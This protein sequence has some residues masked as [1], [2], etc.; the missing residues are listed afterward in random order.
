ML[1]LLAEVPQLVLVAGAHDPAGVIDSVMRYKPDVLLLDHEMTSDVHAL[2]RR[3]EIDFSA[4]GPRVLL[5]SAR[6]HPA[7]E[8]SCAD[9]RVCGFVREQSPLAQIHSALRMVGACSAPRLWQGPCG[10]FPLIDSIALSRL[11]L[12]DREY[13]V[14]DRIGRGQG[15]QHIAI[16]LGL[17]VKTV[18]THRESIKHK[19]RLESASALADP[20]E[21]GGV[22]ITPGP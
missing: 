3:N 15:T 7:T 13:H 4:S 6:H 16:E 2:A 9:D 20:P 22:A 19:L 21:A 5:I 8:S 18:E 1:S 17:S 14:F 12:S 10:S 11:G